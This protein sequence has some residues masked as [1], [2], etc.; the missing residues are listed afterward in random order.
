[1]LND[2]V[3]T[4]L[5]I[6]ALLLI[7]FLIGFQT[8]RYLMKQ[9][10]QR[11]IETR[12]GPKLQERLMERLDLEDSQREAVAPILER[13][14]SELNS[15]TKASMQKRKLLIDSMHNEL[16]PLL[17]PEQVESL[18]KFSERMKRMRKKRGKNKKGKNHKNDSQPVNPDDN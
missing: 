4:V 12:V 3:K 16:R 6:L 10:L 15:V 9:H 2:K 18:E 1:M 7:G 13:Y 5:A 8:N 17:T 11:V 14:T